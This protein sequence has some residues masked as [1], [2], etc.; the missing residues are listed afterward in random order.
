[1]RRVILFVVAFSLVFASVLAPV[2]DFLS[3]INF[4]GGGLQT[5]DAADLAPDTVAS[6]TTDNGVGY[7]FQRKVCFAE[8][9]WWVAY[10]NG[11]DLVV[12]SSTDGDTWSAA[13]VLV[14]GEDNSTSLSMWYDSDNIC[15]AY[16]SGDIRIPQSNIASTPHMTM[17]P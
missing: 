15:F 5:V 9:R 7:P 3:R 16:A 17:E 13:T 10:D 12:K 1:M 6:I 2:P 4:T 14:A 8:T 11:T